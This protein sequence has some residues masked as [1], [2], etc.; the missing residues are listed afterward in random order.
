MQHTTHI[1]QGGSAVSEAKLRNRFKHLSFIAFQYQG[2]SA[3][4]EAK[5]R[6]CFKHL[7]F[8]GS[9]AESE[10]KMRNRF[11]HLYFIAFQLPERICREWSQNE[12]LL[13]TLVF[14]SIPAPREA[15]QRVK[16]KW[17]TASNTYILQCPSFQRGAKM[18]NRF[19]H[20]YF[21]AFQLPER[22]CKA[23]SQN[24]A[25]LQTFVFYS[26]PAP[27]EDL[28]R[29]KPKWGTAYLYFKAFQLPER[30]CRDWSRNEE[31]LQTLVFY[32]IPVPNICIL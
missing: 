7:Y 3:E 14:Y 21:T 17:G 25:P 13:Q 27:R 5:M 30:I 29:V 2:G 20:F 15:L 23:W 9:S 16:Q 8:T 12:E 4:N 32:S 18:R 6:N 24:E 26:M 28:Q 19:K 22:I 31:P 11:K 10:A 1:S